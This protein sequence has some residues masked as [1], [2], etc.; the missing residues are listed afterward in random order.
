MTN[1][2]L[3]PWSIVNDDEL[4]RL[5]TLEIIARKY[6]LHVLQD[7][8]VSGLSVAGPDRNYDFSVDELRELVRK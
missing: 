4:T 3:R 2:L 6:V 8:Q 5:R 7:P 1:T